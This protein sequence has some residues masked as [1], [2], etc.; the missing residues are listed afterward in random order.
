MISMRSRRGSANRI[1]H[2]RRGDEQHLRKIERHVQ[3]V[4]AE[5]GVLLRIQRFQQRRSRIAAEI[6]PELVDFVEHENRIVG[7]GAANALDDLPRQRADVSAAMA[8]NL[9]FVVHAAQRDADELASQRPR[10]RLAQRSLAHSRRSDEAQDRPLHARLQPPHGKIVQDAIL[11]LLQ[12]VVIRVQNFLGLQNV[13]FAAGSLRPR[14][15]RQPL[16]VVAGHGVIGA[17]GDMRAS[18]PSSFSASFFTSSGMPAASIFCAQFFGVARA[19]VLLTQFFL[20]GLH[21]L[22]QVVLALGLLDAILHFRLDLVAQLLDFQLLGQMLVDLF[23]THPDVGASPA[24]P[25]YRRSKATAA[26]RR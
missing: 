6:A 19:F 21:L 11:H 9:R 12:V 20:D 3:I 25:A 18:R 5:S 17:I 7:L 4:V 24:C 22:A 26:T 1:E 8:A 15:R 23:Q 13:H 2:V 10:D 14:Q 16:H